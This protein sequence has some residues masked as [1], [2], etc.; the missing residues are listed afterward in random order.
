VGRDESSIL[1]GRTGGSF[2]GG[3][4]ERSNEDESKRNAKD[5]SH[6]LRSLLLWWETAMCRRNSP[7]IGR[8]KSLTVS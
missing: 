2:S 5:R 1:L 4:D 6:E 8:S 3:E 7:E